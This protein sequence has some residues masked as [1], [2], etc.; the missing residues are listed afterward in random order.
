MVEFKAKHI[1][2]L[3]AVTRAIIGVCFQEYIELIHSTAAAGSLFSK[4]ISFLI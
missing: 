2:L 3:F 1:V 4:R